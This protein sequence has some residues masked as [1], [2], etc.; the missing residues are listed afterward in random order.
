MVSPG[1]G[2]S[3]GDSL[4]RGVTSR[5]FGYLRAAL[6]INVLIAALLASVYTP[7]K[8]AL[9]HPSPT[10]TIPTCVLVGPGLNSG[11]PLSPWQE[12]FPFA[13][14]ATMRLGKYCAEG[15]GSL[16]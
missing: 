7:G 15:T 4:P 3:V 6:R 1:M 9:A 11:P 14:A 10:L 2:L 8:P 13:P 12:S 16:E 5:E